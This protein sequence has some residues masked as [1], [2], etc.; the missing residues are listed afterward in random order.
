MKKLILTRISILFRISCNKKEKTVPG[1]ITVID[2]I[3]T[4]NITMG[5]LP[6][7]Q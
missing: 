6:Y 2:A 4:C 1:T 7:V 5:E 3:Q